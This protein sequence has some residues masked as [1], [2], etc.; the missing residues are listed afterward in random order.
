[1][2]IK[3]FNK[4]FDLLKNWNSKVFKKYSKKFWWVELIILYDLTVLIFTPWYTFIWFFLLFAML[5]L[6][7]FNF[8]IYLDML[9]NEEWDWRIK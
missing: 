7:G 3:I 8:M 4:T 2:K 6:I 1:M 5:I 9:K